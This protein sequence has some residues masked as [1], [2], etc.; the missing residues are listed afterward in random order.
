MNDNIKA[1][2]E[3]LGVCADEDEQFC[4]EIEKMAEISAE[5]LGVD[6]DTVLTSCIKIIDDARHGKPVSSVMEA[7]DKAIEEAEE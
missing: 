2:V 4:A 1:F 6:S 7:V 3:K 5:A